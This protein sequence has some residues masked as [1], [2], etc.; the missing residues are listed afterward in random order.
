MKR[1]SRIFFTTI[2][3][4]PALLWVFY[5]G[6]TDVVFYKQAQMQSAQKSE[7]EKYLEARRSDDYSEN[8]EVDPFDD[9]GSVKVLLVGLDSRVGDL[10]GHCDAIQFFDINRETQEVEIT[11]VPRGTYSPLPYGTGTTSTDYYVSNACGLGGLDYGIDQIER[12]LGEKADYVVVVG[13]SET[14]GIIRNLGLPANKT[15]QW[16]RH[17]K[18]YGVG[19]PQRAKN[20]STFLKQVLVK[21]VPEKQTTKDSLLQ[22]VT[23][24]MVQTDL[25]FEQVQTILAELTKMDLKNNP[26]RV[27]LSMKPSFNVQDIPYDPEKIDE[28]LEAVL[29]PFR[30]LIS[31][32]DYSDA[33]FEDVQ[34]KLLTL[35]DSQPNNADFTEWLY[36]NNIWLQIEN[37]EKRYE[38]QYEIITKYV[39]SLED[40]LEYEH[41]VTDYILE[42]EF[43]GQSAWAEKGEELLKVE[44]EEV[45]E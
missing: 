16:L 19:E 24:K 26:D 45:Q 36:I 1:K 5:V 35:I 4:A 43:H 34:A 42:M 38:K 20:H 33:T 29:E 32:K 31:K 6:I 25:N 41:I 28:H 27:E 23:Y 39:N 22:Y 9:D 14:L 3:F 21:F 11:A 13:F 8:P 40:E 17:R 10:H 2:I 12:I 7:V 37:E 44:E 15:L 30:H 18:G